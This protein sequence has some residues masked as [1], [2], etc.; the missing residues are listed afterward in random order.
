MTII[1]KSIKVVHNW[2]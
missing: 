1:F 2:A